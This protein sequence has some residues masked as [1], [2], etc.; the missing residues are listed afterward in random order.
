MATRK[1][2]V[3]PVERAGGLDN[4]IRRW[5]QNPTKNLGGLVREGMSVL[6]FGGGP[7]HFTLDTATRVGPSGRVFAVDLQEGMLE[8]LRQKIRLTELEQ[9]IILRKCDTGSIIPSAVGGD[10]TLGLRASARFRCVST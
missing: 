2:R 3:C 4:R 1:G 7:G 5:L 8:K 9:R 10:Y 6:D